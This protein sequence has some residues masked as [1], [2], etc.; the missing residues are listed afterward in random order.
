[1]TLPGRIGRLRHRVMIQ[2]DSGT[3]DAFGEH[4]PNWTVLA[5]NVPAEI[6]T[7]SGS[8]RQIAEQL[9]A[10]CTHKVTIRYRSDVTPKMRVVFGSRTLNIEHAPDPDGRRRKLEL[11]CKELV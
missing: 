5:A 2:Q 7:P 9:D 6:V 3:A 11:L 10:I 1:M 4:V 8:E